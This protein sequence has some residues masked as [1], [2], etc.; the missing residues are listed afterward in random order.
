MAVQISMRRVEG[1]FLGHEVAGLGSPP[2]RAAVADQLDRLV[3]ASVT[4]PSGRWRVR[5]DRAAVLDNAGTMGDLAAILRGPHRS[6][7]RASRCSRGS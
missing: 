3:D 2:A 6:P 1:A 4:R 5:P 7:P